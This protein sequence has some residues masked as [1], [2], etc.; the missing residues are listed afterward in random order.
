MRKSMRK[1]VKL[2][3]M[4]QALT[5]I[6]VNGTVDEKPFARRK[7]SNGVTSRFI[8]SERLGRACSTV[9]VLGGRKVL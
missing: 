2:E 6:K 8:A 3:T 9:T 1:A 7:L 4:V 5:A